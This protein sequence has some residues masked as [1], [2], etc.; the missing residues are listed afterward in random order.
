MVFVIK[1]KMPIV[2]GEDRR[3]VKIKFIHEINND[4]LNPGALFL[5][6]Y[7]YESKNESSIKR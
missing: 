3:T 4:I 1:N 2:K 6:G 7:K 5:G